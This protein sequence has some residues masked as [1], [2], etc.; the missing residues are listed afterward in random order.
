MYF[1]TLSV[2][3]LGTGQFG[4]VWL[5]EVV[6]I[7]A[8]HPRDML[9]ERESAGRFSFLWRKAKRNRNLRCTDVTNVAIKSIKGLD[10]NTLQDLR[11]TSYLSFKF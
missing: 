2:N 3:E 7:S 11:D 9:K 6:G 10:L 1:I 8:F 5:A 4:L